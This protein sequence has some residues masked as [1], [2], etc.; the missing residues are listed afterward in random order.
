MRAHSIYARESEYKQSIAGWGISRLATRLGVLLLLVLLIETSGKAA[1][2]LTRPSRS[3]AGLPTAG[4]AAC[5]PDPFDVAS[6]DPRLP[7]RHAR[8]STLVPSWTDADSGVTSSTLIDNRYPLEHGGEAASFCRQTSTNPQVVTLPDGSWLIYTYGNSSKVDASEGDSIMLTERTPEGTFRRYREPVLAFPPSPNKFWPDTGGLGLGMS[9]IPTP[10]AVG[11]RQYRFFGIVGVQNFRDG[12]EYY[13][14]AASIDG[15]EWVFESADGK[16]TTNPFE[17]RVFLSSAQ[18][19]DASHWP[20]VSRKS[21]HGDLYSYFSPDTFQNFHPVMFLSEEDGYVYCFF[22]HYN[23]AS[24]IRT[25]LI[26]F[27]L[28]YGSDFGHPNGNFMEIWFNGEGAEG[29]DPGKGGWEEGFSGILSTRQSERTGEHSFLWDSVDPMSV[30]PLRTVDGK[31]AGML[32]VY[33]GSEGYG[34]PKINVRIALRQSWPFEWGPAMSIDLQELFAAGYMPCTA[35]GISTAIVQ[36][37]PSLLALVSTAEHPCHITQGASRLL[38]CT[39]Q[40]G[41]LKLVKLST[42]RN[43]DEGYRDGVSGVTVNPASYSEH[44]T[45]LCD[46]E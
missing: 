34:S 39:N 28:D 27:K 14:W 23:P 18:L 30:A 17:A 35:G 21:D 12:L 16:P 36:Q 22:G 20:R 46:R 10:A 37:G 4:V 41:G 11:G 43:V 32:M 3:G 7:F 15:R 13:A 45:L 26:R 33:D 9:V 25:Y 1:E 44:L 19:L 38:G 6:E 5:G 2:E 42:I 8:V 40:S 29:Y 24:V 31:P